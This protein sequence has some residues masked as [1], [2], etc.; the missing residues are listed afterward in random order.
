M[1]A[2]TKPSVC[3]MA[4]TSDHFPRPPPPQGSEALCFRGNQPIMTRSLTVKSVFLTLFAAVFGLALLLLG[5]SHA[6]RQAGTALDEANQSRYHEFLLATELRQSSDALTRLARSYVVTG[7]TTWREQY[8]AVVDIRAGLAPLPEEYMRV[9]WDYLA[10]GEPSPRDLGPAAALLERME[11]A[12]FG[13]AERRSTA[14]AEREA[15]AMTQA[16]AS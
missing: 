16:E 4:I 3:G 1:N 7:D 8:Q 9:H 5:A 6:S 14:L 13:D 10:A 11:A 15:Q 2:V 12:G